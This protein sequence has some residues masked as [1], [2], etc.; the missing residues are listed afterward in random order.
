MK[1]AICPFAILLTIASISESRTWRVNTMGTGDAPDLYAAMDSA[2]AYDSVVVEAGEY[3]LSDGLTVPFG[4]RLVGESGPG[5]TLLSLQGAESFESLG[6]LAGAKISGCHVK[7]YGITAD[8]LFLHDGADADHC[9]V[10]TSNILNALGGV[11]PGRSTVL[12]CLF[13]G[14][15]INQAADFAYCIFLSDLDSAAS[16]S[17]FD[18]CDVLGEVAPGVDVPSDYLNFSLDP[19]FCGI[20]GSGNYFLQTTSPCLPANN[21]YTG[22]I[23]GPLGVGCGSVKVETSTWGGVKALY[24]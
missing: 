22:F 6:L 19:L 23:V 10:E 15:K 21:P 12:H 2:A 18:T 9:I 4:V 3:V 7:A 13:V 5:Y 24:R 14:G 11:G 16:G 8:A 1:R 17:T 20:P